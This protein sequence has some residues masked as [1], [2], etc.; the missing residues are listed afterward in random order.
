MASTKHIHLVVDGRKPTVISSHEE[1]AKVKYENII[2]I[3]RN[4]IHSTCGEKSILIRFAKDSQYLHGEYLVY[5]RCSKCERRNGVKFHLF[6][7]KVQNDEEKKLECHFGIGTWCDDYL[8]SLWQPIQRAKEEKKI[9]SAANDAAG[10][11]L[12]VASVRPSG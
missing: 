4:V 5:V 2:F 9:A 10:S 6:G 11:I 1:M 8:F 12:F 7:A 3:R